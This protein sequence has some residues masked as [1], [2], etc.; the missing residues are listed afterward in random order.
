MSASAP[1]QLKDIKDPSHGDSLICVIPDDSVRDTIA[2]MS[3]L[4]IGAVVV[5]GADGRAVG[6]FTERDVVN[7][8]S[9]I[10]RD[11]PP[12][13]VGELMTAD[14]VC[15]TPETSLG[16]A[17]GLMAERGFR[18]LIIND[19]AGHPAGI[20]SMRDLLAAYRTALWSIFEP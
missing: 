2:L 13:L 14:P 12:V 16:H 5:I 3:Q 8:F 7:K 9:S 4:R 10:V 11:G 17:A 1:V 20:V 18:H 6:I 15:V 19:G